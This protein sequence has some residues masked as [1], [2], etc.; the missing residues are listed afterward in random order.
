[1]LHLM[2]IVVTLFIYL[3]FINNMAQLTLKY[4]NEFE[5]LVW[6]RGS[7]E[8]FIE[9]FRAHFKEDPTEKEITNFLEN[10]SVLIYWEDERD[11][12]NE[13]YDDDDYDY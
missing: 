8:K 3:Q 4:L 6:S 7:R 1:M 11:Y 10:V 9:L 12:D 13:Y 5:S 2:T